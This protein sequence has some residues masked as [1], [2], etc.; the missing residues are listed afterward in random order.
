[1]Q[2]S[3][4]AFPLRRWRYYLTLCFPIPYRPLFSQVDVAV[5]DSGMMLLCATVPGLRWQQGLADITVNMRG[6]LDQP[7]ADGVAHV[8]R[9]V[10]AAPW[11]PRPMT[12]FGATVRLTSNVLSVESLEG[13]TGRKV[14][15]RPPSGCRAS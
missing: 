13:H 2:T 6:T 11:L 1:M 15:A 7:V 4:R 9:A 14:S 10:L 3:Y 12:G 8:H 5:K